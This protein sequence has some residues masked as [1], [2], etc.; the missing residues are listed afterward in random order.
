VSQL[1]GGA[2][3]GKRGG[4]SGEKRKIVGDGYSINY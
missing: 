3:V 2:L 1:R 4:K